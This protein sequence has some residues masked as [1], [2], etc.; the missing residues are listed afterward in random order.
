MKEQTSTSK[1]DLEDLKTY[2]N[3]I[4]KYSNLKLKLLGLDNLTSSE[5]E[6]I[7]NFK[8]KYQISKI[9]NFSNEKINYELI[10]LSQNIIDLKK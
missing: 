5:L 1:L 4:N 6:N 2:F 10:T 8:V 7:S 9:I 3:Q